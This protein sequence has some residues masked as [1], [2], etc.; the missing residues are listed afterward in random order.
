[1]KNKKIFW[2]LV[3][4]YWL[5]GSQALA[6]TPEELRQAIEAK[7][8]ALQEVNQKI[9]QTQ[10]ELEETQDK[11]KTLQKE[12]K[13][14]DQ[15]IGQLNL[16]IKASEINISRLQLE[17]ES[18]NY[19]SGVVKSKMA[20]KKSGIA[21]ILKIF[22]RKDSENPLTIFLKNQS[23]AESVAEFQNLAAFNDNLS[24][25]IGELEALNGELAK[26][27]DLTSQKKSNIELGNKNLKVQKSL[28]SGQKVEKQSLLAQTKNQEKVYQSLISDLE[29][30][31]NSIS[32]EIGKIED[33]LRSTF[34]PSLLPGKRPGVFA[35]P[36]K[37]RQ[38]GGTGYITQ[39][40]GEKSY[41]YRGKS[42]N[43][44]D[45][46]GAPIGT[47]VF[48]ADDGKVTATD[49]NDV[50][51]W[52]KYQYGKYVLIQHNNNLSTLYAHLSAQ[53]AQPGQNVK[54][55]D[56]IGYV[57]KTGYATGPHLHFGV[58][59]TPSILMKTILPAAGLVPVGVTIAPEDYL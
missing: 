31:Q 7:N 44:M 6:V 17:L 47:P 54:R 20:V 36:V 32:D 34:D 9:Q 50:N 3:I 51:S 19:D 10:K 23:L 48:A 5:L 22:Q 39:H 57:G 18:L 26:N 12:I 2:L 40:Y 35:W 46:G 24:A 41:L 53:A 21:Q 55:G 8:K 43:G 37:M 27:I 4:G 29:K 45:I 59:W 38:D 25:E 52:K 49:N 13:K 16:G 30:Q 28:V 11:G 1:M 56:L 42:H 58:Y 14:S 15:Q 33:Q